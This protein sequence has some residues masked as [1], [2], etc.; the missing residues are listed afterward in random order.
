MPPLP[1]PT[2][3]AATAF[4]A[5]LPTWCEGVASPFDRMVTCFNFVAVA[6]ACLGPRYLPSACPPP[7]TCLYAAAFQR[8]SI[9]PVPSR[10]VTFAWR[11]M[12]I[13]ATHTLPYCLALTLQR[14]FK[15]CSFL[16]PLLRPPLHTPPV[17]RTTAPPVTLLPSCGMLRA[18]TCCCVPCHY[19]A[20]EH[21]LQF[22]LLNCAHN[23]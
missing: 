8:P 4:D 3:P 9:T 11:R 17:T 20:S 12:G 10:C 13:P 6:R 15:R 14:A 1:S 23:H 18:T 22:A 19:A 5:P 16:L 7:L 2:L 21:Y